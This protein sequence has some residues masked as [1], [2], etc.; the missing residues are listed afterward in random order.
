MSGLILPSYVGPTEEKKA[1]LSILEEDRVDSLAPTPITF[2]ADASLVIVPTL[3]KPLDGK[4][5]LPLAKKIATPYS[6]I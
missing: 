4:P 2:L 1:T 5:L 6:H 3:P